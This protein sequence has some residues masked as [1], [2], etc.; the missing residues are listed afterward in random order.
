MKYFATLLLGLLS[1]KGFAQ[2]SP[3]GLEGVIKDGKLILNKRMINKDWNLQTANLVLGKADRFT[4]GANR[5]YLYDKKGIVVYEAKRNGRPTGMINELGIH[6]SIPASN[7]IIPYST[8]PGSFNIEGI[9]ITKDTRWEDISSSLE[10]QGYKKKGPYWYSKKGIY[11][12]FRFSPDS[13]LE[14]LSIGKG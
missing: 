1:L 10:A 5:V 4:E 8:Y 11:I 2:K 3:A 7:V 9:A 14:Y 12:I 13:S 6:F